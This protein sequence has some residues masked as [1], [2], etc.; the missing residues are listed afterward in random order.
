MKDNALLKRIQDANISF[1]AL[2]VPMSLALTILVNLHNL[3]GHAGAKNI[4]LNQ[5]RL[6]LKRN[7]QRH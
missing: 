4:L 6:L 3:Q 5:K 1:E 2:V 7:V